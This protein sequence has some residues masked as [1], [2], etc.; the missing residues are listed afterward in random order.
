MSQTDEL[1]V[2]PFPDVFVGRPHTGGT[3]VDAE[4]L[5]EPEWFTSDATQ[6]LPPQDFP[7]QD[8]PPQSFPPR[9]LS[10]RMLSPLAAIDYAI[11]DAAH[12]QFETNRTMAARLSALAEVLE[13][14]RRNPRVYLTEVGMHEDDPAGFAERSAAFEAALRLRVTPDQ[15]LNQAREGQVLADRL[16]RLW[17]LFHSGLISY[18]QASAA[19]ELQISLT[20][21][22]VARYDTELAKT[23]AAQTAKAFRQKAR[24]LRYRLLAER[25]ELRHARAMIDRRVTVEPADD[26]MAW[27][28]AFIS[29]PDAIRIKARLDATAKRDVTTEKTAAVKAGT[30]VDSCRTQP[31]ARADLL[32]AW[33]AGDGTPTAAKVRPMLFVRMLGLLGIGGG[34]VGPT[35]TGTVTQPAVLQGYGPID[36]VTAAQLFSDAPAFRRVGTDPFTGEILNFD[37]R[38]YRPTKAQRELLAVKFGT[39]ANPDC[40]RLA[41]NCDIDHVA[42]WARDHGLTNEDN[43][44]PLCARDHRLKTLTKIRYQ[45]DPDGS[46]TLTTPTGYVVRNTPT[47]PLPENPPF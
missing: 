47:P 31:Q 4:R 35:G 34:D 1:P 17:D 3:V 29:A 23:A 27:L 24:E 38:R 6:L 21:A 9:M 25:P 46:V 30:P 26:G 43:L 5:L 19:V 22:A 44:I 36:P 45:R 12:A 2:D 16:P 13:L 10:P 11:D 14:A 28:H 41:I 39:C 15:V 33:L 37:R 40:D 8:F 20:D 32:V 42:E 7:P 18:V